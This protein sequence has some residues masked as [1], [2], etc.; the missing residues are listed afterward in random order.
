MLFYLKRSFA[1]LTPGIFSPPV[2]NFYPA[3]PWIC[4]SSTSSHPIPRRRGTGKVTEARFEFRERASACPVWSSPQTASS[5][6]PYTPANPWWPNNHVQKLPMV[7]WNSPWRPPSHI[8]PAKGYEATPPSS[9]NC[10]AV[11]AVANSPSQFRLS[12]FFNKLFKC[13]YGLI[14]KNISIS[15][16]SA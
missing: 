13:K 7:S 14:V 11:R 2:Q 6:L 3:I 15:S 8:Q 16:Y 5:I 10:D 9:T 1:A 4:Y 12:H